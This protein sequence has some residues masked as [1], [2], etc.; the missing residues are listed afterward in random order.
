MDKRLIPGYLL[1]LTLVFL[2]FSAYTIYQLM[3]HGLELGLF[4]TLL[5]WSVYVLCV[6]AA[7]GRLLIGSGC[8]LLTGRSF[9]PEPYL[10]LFAALLN[11][12]TI[13][14]APEVYTQTLMTYIFYRSVFIPG[15][16]IIFVLA[17]AGTWYRSTIGTAAYVARTGTHTTIRHLLT[18]IGLLVLFYLTHQDFIVLLNA[19]V[20]G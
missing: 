3:Q 4:L 19:T 11:I 10:W 13:L 5:S 12:V 1:I 7:H 17:A 2:L 6:P 18:L 20:S 9:F 14:F 8:K 15:Y 16:W